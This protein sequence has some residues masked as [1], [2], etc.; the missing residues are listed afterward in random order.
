MTLISG[1]INAARIEGSINGINK[2]LYIFM[3]YHLPCDK[4]M[5]CP[6]T[7]DNDIVQYIDKNIRNVPVNTTYDFFVESF[8]SDLN[9]NLTTAKRRYIDEVIRYFKISKKNNNDKN[10]NDKNNNVKK[11]IRYHHIDVREQAEKQI[12][13]NIHN[14]KNELRESIFDK[15]IK[16]T[17]FILNNVKFLQSLVQYFYDLVYQ[18]NITGD[19]RVAYKPLKKMFIKYNNKNVKDIITNFVNNK[20]KNTFTNIFTLLDSLNREINFAIDKL[21]HKKNTLVLHTSYFE[22]FYSYSPDINAMVLNLNQAQQTVNILDRQL[23]VLLSHFV[24]IYFLRRFLDKD[25][26]KNCIAYVG[27]YHACQIIHFLVNKLDFK[28]TH[29]SYSY[30]ENIDKLNEHI[31]TSPFDY[32]FAKCFYPDILTQCSD[33]TNFPSNFA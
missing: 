11:V 27:I 1:P 13:R 32:E 4:Q 6:D 29:V 20:M 21:H 10:N 7:I 9:D 24:D 8:P 30:P 19:E 22:H 31:K 28:V 25:Y 15:N 3:D 12:V 5:Q 26:V 16:D 2:I 14:I 17:D 33:I 18:D 23:I